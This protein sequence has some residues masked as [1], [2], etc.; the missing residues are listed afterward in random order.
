M[1]KFNIDELLAAMEKNPADVLHIE[2]QKDANG[3]IKSYKAGTEYMKVKFQVGGVKSNAVI[4]IDEDIV[5]TSG[6]PDPKN[7]KDKRNEYT[8]DNSIKLE[9]SVLNSGKIGKFLLMLNAEYN[10][11]INEM[12]EHK[13][14]V[15][16]YNKIHQI[17]QTHYSDDNDNE[18][19]RGQKIMRNGVEDPKYRI[20]IDFSVYDEK[21]QIK[22]LVGLPKSVVQNFKDYTY[23][24]K[25]KTVS[26]GL[27]QVDG[28]FVGL[29]N[30]HEFITQGSK[31]KSGRLVLDSATNSKF[32]V[33][34]RIVGSKVVIERNDTPMDNSD[35]PSERILRE[36]EEMERKKA[37][38]KGASDGKEGKQEEGKVGEKKDEP[39]QEE[40]KPEQKTDDK[41][42]KANDAV[43]TFLEGL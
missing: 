14:F 5:I 39:K 1:K 23:D 27:A 41:T 3:K 26:Y 37:A 2:V 13:V 33:S 29:N 38:A 31:I 7:T 25:T 22:E 19:L 18:K 17:V 16:K 28:K 30:I 34:W 40:K 6:L 32:G 20:M 36:I 8:G 35:Q 4:D 10:R 12:I 21:C 24:P 15:P 43:N 11:Q 9:T 42:A